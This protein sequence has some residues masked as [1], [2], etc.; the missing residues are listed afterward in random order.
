[1]NRTR[2]SAAHG[3]VTAA[4]SFEPPDRIPRFDSF[5]EYP[6]AWQERLGSRDGLTDIHVRVPD[7]G[8]FPT[9]QRLLREE[10]GNIYEV[11][12]W[13]RTVRRRPGAYFYQTV[14][15]PIPESTDPDS[16]VFDPPGLDERYGRDTGDPRS[17]EEQQRLFCVFGKTGGPYLRTTFV[18]GEEQFL[19][20]IASDPPLARALADKVADHLIGI[21]RE[22]IRRWGLQDTGVWIYDDMAGNDGPMFSPAAFERVFLPAYRRMVREYKKAGARWV[23]LH[24]DGNILPLLDMLVDAGVDGINPIE[25]RAGMRLPEIRRRFPRL[26]L[27]GGMDNSGSMIRGPAALLEREAAAIIEC[28]RDGGVVIGTHSIS[29]EIPL[30]HYE[31]YHR[32][33]LELGDFSRAPA[34]G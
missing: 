30:A 28:G 18:R 16:V 26:V 14:A 19:T 9:R 32:T 34:S 8:T 24:S 25:P 29:P 22:Q 2:P 13:G 27:T 11:D 15:V 6:Q 7:E 10:S 5:W 4:F 31:A 12:T 3:R 1:V 33:C 21:A 17:L 20:D 23:V